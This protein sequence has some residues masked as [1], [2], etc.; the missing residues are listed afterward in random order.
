MIKALVLALGISA[1]AGPAM[2]DGIKWVSSTVFVGE[3]L[4]SSGVMGLAYYPS[5]IA[6]T[7]DANGLYEVWVQ[8]TPH[9]QESYADH[10]AISYRALCNATGDNSCV[11]GQAGWVETTHSE[12]I[13][14]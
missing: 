10:E 1:L 13:F 6:I 5:I 12:A 7:P 9:A 4:L 8:P 3:K 2:A 14:P 11:N